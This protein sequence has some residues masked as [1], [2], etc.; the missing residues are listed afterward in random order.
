MPAKNFPFQKTFAPFLWAFAA[1]SFVFL[2]SC[3]LAITPSR[4]GMNAREDENFQDFMDIPYPS[5]MTIEKNKTEVFTRRNVLSGHISIVGPLS[6]DELLDYY[7]R[8]L[9][10]H[11]WTPHAE[12]QLESETVSTWAKPGKTLTII[13]T[14]PALSIGVKSRIDLYVAPPHTEA[15]LGHRTIYLDTTPSGSSYSTTPIRE[16]G[17]GG[18]RSS[19]IGEEDL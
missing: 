12:V 13:A 19:G 7:D 4:E 5:E 9:P 1:L 15:D 10:H 16:S 3:T 11:G 14:K 2:A 17:L 18:R 8:H 6:N